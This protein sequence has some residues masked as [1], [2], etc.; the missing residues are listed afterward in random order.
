MVLLL[1]QHD[2]EARATATELK[3]VRHRID[4]GLAVRDLRLPLFKEPLADGGLVLLQIPPDRL[5]GQRAELRRENLAND[6]LSV[7][8]AL[9][10]TLAGVVGA[11][12]RAVDHHLTLTLRHACRLVRH[13]L[14]AVFRCHLRATNVLAALH[15][16]PQSYFAGRT[17]IHF[18]ENGTVHPPEI[19]SGPAGK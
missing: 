16:L 12:V 19:K 11:R 3:P 4:L 5:R 13:T 9:C 2:D 6:R 17:P 15:F 18:H 7:N 14:L 1:R 10:L 8:G